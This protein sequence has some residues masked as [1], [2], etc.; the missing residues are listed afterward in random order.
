MASLFSLEATVVVT[1]VAT[2]PIFANVSPQA[3]CMSSEELLL[4]AILIN[5]VN[6]KNLTLNEK[7]YNYKN[8]NRECGKK[9][10]NIYLLG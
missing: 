5:S 8:S 2:R 1:T 4:V 7:K 6:K 3:K 10:S 9:M